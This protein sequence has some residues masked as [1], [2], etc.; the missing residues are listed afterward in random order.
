MQNIY[1]EPSNKLTL[2]PATRVGYQ[3]Q[4]NECL[5][6]PASNQGPDSVVFAHYLATRVAT[7]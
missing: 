4:V 3:R 2:S 1:T 7:P 5:D 6:L